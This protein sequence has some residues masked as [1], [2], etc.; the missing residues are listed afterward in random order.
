[1]TCV[2]RDF[3]DQKA[4]LFPSDRTIGEAVRRVIRRRWPANAAKHLEREWD[5]DPKTA[6]N[7]VQAGAVSE[8]TL[9]KAIRAEGWGLLNELGE[10]L[11]GHTYDQHLEL[12]I[13]ET[14][15]A[16]ERLARRRERIRD[17][18]ARASELVRMGHGVGSGLDR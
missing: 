1:M 18:E 15:R 4:Q 13:E 11:T 17:L 5:L 3:V 10:A 6:K 7:V 9:T 2:E 14:R 8:R 16:K 12:R